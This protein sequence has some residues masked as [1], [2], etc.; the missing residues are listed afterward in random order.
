MTDDDAD[1]KLSDRLEA[2][3]GGDGRKT[4]SGLVETFGPQS[5]AIVFV[6]AMVMQY[7][8]RRREDV[9]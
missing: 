2:W 5:F 4:M 1:E 8:L 6:I 9:L 7:Y 3:L